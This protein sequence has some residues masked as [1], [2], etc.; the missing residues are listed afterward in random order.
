MLEEE[1]NNTVNVLGPIISAVVLDKEITNLEQPVVI[2]IVPSLVGNYG[3]KDCNFLRLR[4]C[5]NML[6]L[7]HY[8]HLRSVE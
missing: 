2:K 4:L 8:E 7:I 1:E 5:L 6:H 3:S